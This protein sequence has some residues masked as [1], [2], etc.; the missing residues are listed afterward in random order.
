MYVLQGN[1]YQQMFSSLIN[2]CSSNFCTAVTT[3]A[4]ITN[5]LAR[6]SC[7]QSLSNW[8]WPLPTYYF[9]FHAIIVQLIIMTMSLRSSCLIVSSECSMATLTHLVGSTSV[10]CIMLWPLSS[11]WYICSASVQWMTLYPW[12]NGHRQHFARWIRNA[13]IYSILPSY[14]SSS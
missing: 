3:F 11:T 12:W 2:G 9:H 5:D 13:Y 4:S 1:D 6:P 10:Q 8:V 7:M 14:S